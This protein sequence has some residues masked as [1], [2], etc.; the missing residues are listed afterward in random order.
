MNDSANENNDAN[1]FRLSN[2]KTTTTK[3]FEYK[4]KLIGSTPN[5]NSRLD[6][7]VVVPLKYLRNCWRSLNLLL[8]YCEIELDLSCSRY[9]VICEISRTSRVVGNPPPQQMATT[10]TSATFQISNASY[11]VPIVTLIF[12]D[13]N[14][15]LENLKQGFKRTISW[16]KCKPEIITQLRNN[17]LDYLIDPTIRNINRL[18]VLSIKNDNHDATRDSIDKYYMPLVEIKDFH[19]LIDNKPFFDQPV[20]NK[21]EKLIE[22]LIEMSRNNVYT[23][24]NL[25]YYMYP[26]KFYKLIGRDLSSQRNTTIPQQIYFAGK[27]QEDDGGTM[28]FVCEKQQ[29][30]I[31]KFSLDSLIVAK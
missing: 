26:K 4:T 19:A 22:K 20:K 16:N 27:L 7:E 25:L 6:A 17:N 13:N 11:Y 2:S 12:N 1:N 9:F 10:E 14:K 21:Q 29:K 31:L 15:F 30:T 8:I 3:S 24:G 5:N 28:L 23:T 18:Y